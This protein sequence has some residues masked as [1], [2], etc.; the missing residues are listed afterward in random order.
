MRFVLDT[1]EFIGAFKAK[2]NPT[3]SNLLNKLTTEQHPLFI[4]RT[5]INEVRRNLS[6]INF[7][8]FIKFIH[9]IAT[10]HED[11]F[12]PFEIGIKYGSLGLKPADTFIAAYCEWIKAD[13]LVSENRH[14]LTRTSNLPF[15][16]LTAEKT[17]LLLK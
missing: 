13:V 2:P 17:L 11:A 3:V 12:V 10:I 6:T 5:I 4:T 7:S 14:F 16:V 1:N 15:K 9:I 8:R